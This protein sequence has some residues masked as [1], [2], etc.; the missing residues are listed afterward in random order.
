MATHW[1]HGGEGTGT[2]QQYPFGFYIKAKLM[3][4][5]G[6]VRS[7]NRMASTADTFFSVP[8]SVVVWDGTNR[9]N[10]SVAGYMTTETAGGMS[11]PT[12]DDP[13]VYKFVAYSYGKNGHLLPSLTWKRPIPVVQQQYHEPAFLGD[14]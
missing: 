6:K 7:T 10:V 14:K 11:T 3:C 9:K 5:D 4:S 2:Y 1:H 12:D 8:C 13:M